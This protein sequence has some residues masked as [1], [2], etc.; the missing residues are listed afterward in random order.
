MTV[1]AV[2]ALTLGDAAPQTP[3]V[4]AG[5]APVDALIGRW[6]GTSEGQPGQGTQEREYSRVLAGKFVQLRNRAVYPPQGKNP[7]GET[8]EDMGLFSFDTARKR[9]IFR[10]FHVEGFVNQYV[11]DPPEKPGVLLFTTEAIE[12]IPP[13]WRARETYT[14]IGPDEF[15]EVFELSEAGRPFAVYS[16]ARLKRVR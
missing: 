2:S 12:N 14:F 10:Q 4:T 5:L 6:R 13:G 8:H 9:I 7:K 11:M 16:R 1:F 3:A 15:E